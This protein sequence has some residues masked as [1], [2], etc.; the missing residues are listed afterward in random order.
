MNMRRIGVLTFLLLIA[1]AL[2]CLIYFVIED[3]V[4]TEIDNTG[5]CLLIFNELLIYAGALLSEKSKDAFVGSG[6]SMFTIFYIIASVLINL[7]FR[8]LFT[9]FRTF[10]I[11]NSVAFL[12]FA[13]CVGLVLFFK[14][15]NT[16]KKM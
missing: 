5:F 2:S 16:D 7:V 12:I 11:T 10:I 3:S 13:F 9:T 1:I 8:G 14:A 6:V 15:D 4:K